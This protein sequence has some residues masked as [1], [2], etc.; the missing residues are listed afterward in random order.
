MKSDLHGYPPKNP[1]DR[2]KQHQQRR[3]SGSMTSAP[4]S[5][6]RVQNF[7]SSQLPQQQQQSQQSSI[8][9]SSSCASSHA[10]TITANRSRLVQELLEQNS[11]V[12]QKL[13][14]R[15]E[16][17]NNDFSDAVLFEK[18]T[19]TINDNRQHPLSW[20]NSSNSSES[21]IHHHPFPRHPVKPPKDVTVK[22][23]LYSTTQNKY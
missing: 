22:L 14:D 6:T 8:P 18:S 9:L 11:A 21:P 10:L 1:K 5:N 4:C 23:G 15:T 17:T 20:T 3:N 19:G 13:K 2:P 16:V 7:A 12:L